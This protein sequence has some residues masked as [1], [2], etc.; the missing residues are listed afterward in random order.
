[1]SRRAGSTLVELLVALPIMGIVGTLAV[2]LLL[3]AQRQARRG[4]DTN[5]TM[6]ELRH[7]SAVAGAELRPLRPADLVTW[8]DTSIEFNTL[9]GSGVACAT[10]SVGAHIDL[11]PTDDGDAAGTRWVM[12]MQDGDGITAWL[13]AEP[14]PGLPVVEWVS[15][16]IATAPTV[17]CASSA[18][19]TGS[20]TGVRVA[21][22]DSLRRQIAEGSPVRITRRTRHRLYRAGDN[23]WY[24]GRSTR[25]RTGWD[26]NQPIAG[27]FASAALRGLRYTVIDSAGAPLPLGTTVG[28]A[29]VRIELRAPRS[30]GS[31][32]RDSLFVAIALRGRGDA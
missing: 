2:V 18:A 32:D 5:R 3:A 30:P 1:M 13:A 6:R 20:G 9:V 12:P 28:A 25:S 21:V 7:A 19:Y 10:R 4:D 26:V 11:L 15:V 24:I 22:E 31:A 8:S 23:L 27:P 17:S 14:S 29:A 16:A